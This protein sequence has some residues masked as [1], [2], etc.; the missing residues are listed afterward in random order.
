[1]CSEMTNKSQSVVF[2]SHQID[3]KL[4]KTN[5]AKPKFCFHPGFPD[6]NSNLVNCK[7]WLRPSNYSHR[8]RSTTRELHIGHVT[9]MVAVRPADVALTLRFALAKNRHL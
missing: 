7:L 9:Q 4:N 6:F 3:S 1:M 8:P 5:A 2:L